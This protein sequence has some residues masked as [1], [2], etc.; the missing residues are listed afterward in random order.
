MRYSTTTIVVA[1]LSIG[2]TMA[3]PT[4][5]HLHRHRDVHAK[6]DVVDWADLDWDNMGID[7]TSAWKAG[8]HTS[9]VAPTPVPTTAAPVVAAVAVETSAAPVPTPSSSASASPSASAGVLAEVSSEAATLWNGVVGLA[10]KL[11]AF[12]EAAIGSGSEVAAIGNIGSPQGSNMI[13]VDS[14]SGYPFTNTF[15]NTSGKSMTILLWNKAFSNDGTVAS[16]EANLGSCVAA[17]TPALSIALAAGEQQV[18]AFQDQTLMGWA[19]ATSAKTASGALAITW[20][21]ASFKVGGSGYDMSA[22]LNP[23]GNNY[24]MAISSSETPCISDPTQNYW[25][26]ANNNPE[27]PIPIGTSDGSCYVPGSTATLVTKMGGYM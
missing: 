7:W 9:T 17:S 13:K 23:E 22:I 15:I 1:A 5:A 3:G 4:H 27:D 16:A 26:A 25:E 18:V 12:G 10:N 8:Q 19:E 24:Q 11:T 21:E 2:Q 20:G 6:K 14:A